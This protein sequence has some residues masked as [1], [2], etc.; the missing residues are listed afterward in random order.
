MVIGSL[1]VFF[2]N[3]GNSFNIIPKEVTVIF[4]GFSA[5]LP[6]ICLTFFAV[7]VIGYLFFSNY[8]ADLVFG[9]FS[10]QGN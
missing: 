7:Q 6:L 9:F 3:N 1:S 2:C 5:S 8:P 4:V 10:L